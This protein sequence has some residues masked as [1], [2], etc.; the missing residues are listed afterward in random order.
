MAFL[1]E[2]VQEGN[3]LNGFPKTLKKR[4]LVENL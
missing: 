2:R 4:E 3:S 1:V